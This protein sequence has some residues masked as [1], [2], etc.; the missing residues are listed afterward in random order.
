MNLI[1]YYQ[2]SSLTYTPQYES[3]VAFKEYHKRSSKEYNKYQSKS[4]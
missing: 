4:G 1:N 3:K 2:C